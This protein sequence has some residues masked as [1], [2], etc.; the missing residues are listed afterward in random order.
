MLS[1][2]AQDWRS[3]VRRVKAGRLDV[4]GL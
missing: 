2:A 4:L 1:Y 3:F